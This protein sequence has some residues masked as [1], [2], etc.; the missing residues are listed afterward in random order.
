M[1]T[2]LSTEEAARK[3]RGLSKAS[4]HCVTQSAAAFWQRRFFADEQ[5]HDAVER[6]GWRCP[7]TLAETYGLGF[8]PADEEEGFVAWALDHADAVLPEAPDEVGR[9]LVECGVAQRVGRRLRERFRDRVMF[10]IPE[11]VAGGREVIAGFAGRS[12]LPDVERRVPKYINSPRTR[13][14]DKSRVLYGFPWAER[15]I[16]ESRRAVL[17]EGYWDVLRLREMGVADVVSPGGTAL[18]PAQVARLERLTGPAAERAR[19]GPVSLYLMP[20]AD[21]EGVRAGRRWARRAIALDVPVRF[22]SLPDGDPDSYLSRPDATPEEV[23]DMLA[24]ARDL[25]EEVWERASAS[26][27]LGVTDALARLR[28]TLHGAGDHVRSIEVDAIHR[29]LGQ[30]GYTLSRASVERVFGPRIQTS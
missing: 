8:A 5:A 10:P 11:R 27:L 24:R 16:Q 23:E 6:R 25:A 12:V 3:R 13:I 30:A 21:P 19:R 26:G 2:G 29:E 17:V 18:T 28:E 22:I 15:A 14:F 4:L 9:A 20:D 1:G 7:G